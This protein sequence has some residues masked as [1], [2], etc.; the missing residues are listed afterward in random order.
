MILERPTMARL[1]AGM[2]MNSFIIIIINRSLT[3]TMSRQLFILEMTKGSRSIRCDRK[4]KQKK[5][6]GVPR[7]YPKSTPQLQLSSHPL[8]DRNNQALPHHPHLSSSPRLDQNLI[9]RFACWDDPEVDAGLC[10]IANGP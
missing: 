10:G 6:K 5:E 1:R 3:C 4:S 7:V 8:L 9:H 2:S